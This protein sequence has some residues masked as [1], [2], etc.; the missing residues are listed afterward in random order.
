[1]RLGAIKGDVIMQI[2]EVMTDNVQTI[3]PDRSIQEAALLMAQIDAGMLPV[4]ANDRL[5]G[6]ITDR[7][8][9]IRGVAAGKSPDTPVRDV[10]THEVKY[11]FEDED[12][13]DVANSSWE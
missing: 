2:G 7:D 3:R 9:A 10:M 11:C 4:A 8:I 12:V 6:I 5:V 13:E 1:L